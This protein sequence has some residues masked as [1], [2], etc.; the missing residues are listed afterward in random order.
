MSKWEIKL[1]TEKKKKRGKKKKCKC[2][3]VRAS[4]GAAGRKHHGPA[5]PPAP[6]R[7]EQLRAA[8]APGRLLSRSPFVFVEHMGG[9][10]NTACFSH[11]AS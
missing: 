3:R 7:E 5:A 8:P 4:L 10:K 1:F 6:G 11:E 9:N 2:C